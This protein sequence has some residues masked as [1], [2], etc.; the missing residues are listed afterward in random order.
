MPLLYLSRQR[1]K[2]RK[3]VGHICCFILSVRA[4]IFSRRRLTVSLLY[5]RLV[6]LTKQHEPIIRQTTTGSLMSKRSKQL[7]GNNVSLPRGEV[8][9]HEVHFLK[10]LHAGCYLR[11]HVN[12][13][14]ETATRRTGR[15]YVVKF[16]RR[17]SPQ[18]T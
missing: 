10:I 12:Q 11:G 14:A 18:Y 9:M 6:S 7:M 8:P 17:N 13:C 2:N 4:I 5:V 15:L 1:K 3:V 16:T